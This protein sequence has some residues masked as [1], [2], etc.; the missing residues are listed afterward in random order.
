MRKDPVL[1]KNPESSKC[2]VVIPGIS[3]EPFGSPFDEVVEQISESYSIVRI[4]AWNGAEDLEK[5]ALKNLHDL[6]DEACELLKSNDCESISV[7]RKS[8]GGKLAL[9]YP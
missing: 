6:I 3:S 4:N 5:M 9:T 7:L 2:L 1:E 8:F